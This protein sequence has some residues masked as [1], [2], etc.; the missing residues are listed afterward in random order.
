MKKW[1]VIFA[2]II[3]FTLSSS[4]RAQAAE[5]ESEIATDIGKVK[6]GETEDTH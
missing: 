1:L 6:P 5:D 4:I 2:T 3:P